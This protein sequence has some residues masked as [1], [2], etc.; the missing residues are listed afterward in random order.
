MARKI[1]LFSIQTSTD[2]CQ[3]RLDFE[4]FVLNDPVTATTITVGPTTAAA[5]TANSLGACNTDQFSVTAPGGKCE[6]SQ[7]GFIMIFLTLSL[8]QLLL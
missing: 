4:T 8:L 1:F 5:G 7:S 3:L 2:V 6:S